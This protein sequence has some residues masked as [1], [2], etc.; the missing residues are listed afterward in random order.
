MT[1]FLVIGG[2]MALLTFAL[3]TRPLWRR[4]THSAASSYGLLAG[5]V[6]FVGTITVLGYT[7][8]GTPQALDAQARVAAAPAASAAPDGATAQITTAQIES[9][10]QLLDACVKERPDDAE[11][12]TMLGRANA[13]LDRHAL[14]AP[15]FKQ[16]MTLRPDDASLVADYAD[17]LAMASGRSLE[18]EPALLIE[19][20]LKLDPKNLKALSLAGSVAFN[21]KDFAAAIGHWE[22][23]S[24][25]S[26]NGE[27]AAQIQAGIAE[28]RRRMAGGAEPATAVAPG[29][30]ASAA[31]ARLS[32]TVTLAPAL[33]AN[34]RPDDTLFV[35]ARSAD[36]PRMPLAILRKQVKDLP[37][38][39]VLD[40]SMAMS[41]AARLSSA[42]RVVVGA[43]ISRAGD[44]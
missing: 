43:R 36:G 6:V 27:S 44:A 34:A 26:G 42:Q 25:L 11:G 29:K 14:A 28:A 30:A 20:A 32:G 12:W 10:V 17:A 33:A 38:D 39:F 4:P 21:R 9:M 7:W 23:M 3:L 41:P 37:L 5:L 31:G 15:A 1:A 8:I 22:K 13:L 2:L 24:Q 18:G 16:A 40:D 19:R 35:F